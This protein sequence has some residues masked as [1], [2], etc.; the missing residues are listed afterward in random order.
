R[1]I[2]I[3]GSIVLLLLLSWLFVAIFL[4][5]LL[6][7]SMPSIFRQE[8][9]GVGRQSFILYKFRSLRGDDLSL[10]KRVFPLGRFLRRTSLD[11]LPQLVNVLIGDMSFIGPRP[12]PVRYSS[13]FSLTQDRRHR[14]K[15][16]IT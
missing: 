15:P 10:E 9:I 14:L 16:G 11:E 8:R 1:V 13:L 6:S 12:L 7:F 5:F 4:A 3:L 2:D